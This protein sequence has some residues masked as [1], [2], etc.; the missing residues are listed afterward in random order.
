VNE[1]S[2]SS[3]ETLAPGA[4]C[5]TLYRGLDILEV[6]AAGTIT[7]PALSAA[8]G[9]SRSTTH[10]LAAALVDRRYLHF[11]PREGYSLGSRLLD[12]GFRAQKAM[13]IPLIAR[14]LLER[15]SEACEDT[16]HLGVLEDGWALYL[17]KIPG[18]RR[19]EISSRVGE[20]H[21]VW[22]TGLGKALI[23][24]MDEAKWRGFHAKGAPR[25]ANATT[26]VAAWLRRMRVYAK[27][28]VTFDLEENEPQ[29]RCVAAPIRD[30][31]GK[32]V[33]AF[34]VS[35]TVQYMGDDRMLY[36][37][38]DVRQVAV[39]ISQAFGWSSES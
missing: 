29:I 26:E 25:G 24:D 21:P 33:A 3:S 31:S 18:R 4:G 37:A 10:R 30:A 1:S 34:S 23:L 2:Q 16:I 5:Q 13:P 19:V 20:R 36:L 17:D 38:E 32:V 27:R 12:L 11:A 28:G 8:L 22:S 15:L 14:P 6:V 35:S 39:A 7:L 9:M